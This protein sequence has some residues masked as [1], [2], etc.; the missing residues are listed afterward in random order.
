MSE[1]GLEKEQDR[2]AKAR[3]FETYWKPDVYKR[4]K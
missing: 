3:F 1:L 4:I 2:T